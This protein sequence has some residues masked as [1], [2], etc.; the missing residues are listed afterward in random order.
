MAGSRQIGVGPAIFCA[1]LFESRKT[2]ITVARGEH[3]ANLLLYRYAER[4][5][6]PIVIA[7]ALSEL[8][9]NLNIICADTRVIRIALLIASTKLAATGQ[10]RGGSGRIITPS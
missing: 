10:E 1:A 3:A 7:S 6:P 8:N 5:T 4:G 9:D 2:S